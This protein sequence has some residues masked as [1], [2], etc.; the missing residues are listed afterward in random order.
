MTDG[1]E[2][3]WERG[4]R[5]IEREVGRSG[6][7]YRGEE[8]WKGRREIGD[9]KGKGR[10]EKVDER[11][12]SGKGGVKEGNRRKKEVTKLIEGREMEGKVEKR[13]WRGKSD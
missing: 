12:N 5:E 7:V 1:R 13:K 3:K 9:G 10:R 2:V 8:R 4:E 11:E 6:E